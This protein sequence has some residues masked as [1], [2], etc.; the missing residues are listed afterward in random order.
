[1]NQIPVYNS[2]FEAIVKPEFKNATLYGVDGFGDTGNYSINPQI[3]LL[4][5]E[6]GI[7]F[8]YRTV[9]RKPKQITVIALG[10]L[11]TL[12][13]TMKI[14]NDFAE[15]I[16]EIFIMGGNDPNVK[17]TPLK[18][19]FNFRQDPEANDIVI[20]SAKA[21]MTILPWEVTIPPNLVIP[22]VTKISLKTIL[23]FMLKYNLLF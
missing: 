14:Y 18:T 20:R 8:L 17:E 16:K 5:Q 15:N 19:E 6:N 13:L 23:K 7:E 11:T 22:L 9:K 12:A 10:P 4:Q 1:M 21:P 2:A 3:H